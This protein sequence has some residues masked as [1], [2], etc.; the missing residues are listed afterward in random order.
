MITKKGENREK[1]EIHVLHTIFAFTIFDQA[2]W[3]VSPQIIEWWSLGAAAENN[4]KVKKKGA[5]TTVKFMDL[6]GHD[7]HN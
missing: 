4:Q 1:K 3:F 7:E 5:H 2:A 6:Y